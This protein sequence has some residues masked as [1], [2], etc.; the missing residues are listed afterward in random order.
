MQK[1]SLWLLPVSNTTPHTYTTPPLFKVALLL[2][3]LAVDWPLQG[4]HKLLSE[5]VFLILLRHCRSS[6]VKP[7]DLST[8]R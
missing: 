6:T 2:C 7:L 8:A 1:P 3:F 5:G 4:R